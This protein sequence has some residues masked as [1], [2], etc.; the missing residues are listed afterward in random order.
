MRVSGD[1]AT[2]LIVTTVTTPMVLLALLFA[3]QLTLR[4]HTLGTVRAAAQVAASTVAD[5]ARSR[6]RAEDRLRAALG[7]VGAGARV[8]WSVDAE[9]VLVSVSLEPPSLG[10]P[11]ALGIGDRIEHTARARVERWR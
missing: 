6:E 8:D 11:D 10:A 7:E 1:R 5:E 4:L 9:V 2:G 3:T